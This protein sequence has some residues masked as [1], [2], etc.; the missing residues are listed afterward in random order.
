MSDTGGVGMETLMAQRDVLDR[1]LRARVS[2]L[3]EAA[4][5]RG[6]I[7]GSVVSLWNGWA[8]GYGKDGDEALA[9]LRAIGGVLNPADLTP[10]IPSKG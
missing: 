10:P 7:I 6:V 3:E 9:V 2:G 8:V 1:E 4:E 5:R